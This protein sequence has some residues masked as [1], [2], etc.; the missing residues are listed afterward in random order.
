MTDNELKQLVAS[1]AI[2]QQKTDAQLAKTDEKINDLILSQQKTDKEINNLILSQQKTDIQ[3][4]RTSSEVGTLGRGRGEIAEEFFYRSL[5]KN[6]HI[7]DINFDHVY[8]NWAYGIDNVSD[9]YDV[10]LLNGEQLLIVEVK[11]RA[12]TGDFWKLVKTKIPHFRLL[13]PAYKNYKLLGAIASLTSSD[14][15]ISLAKEL[16]VFFLT[17]QGEHVV[18]GNDEVKAF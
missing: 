16:G 3:L 5:S 2:S 17:Q 1:L 6:P 7:G 9:E 13:F 18:L 8:R 11:A 14:K 15:L 4:K 12:D 10:I